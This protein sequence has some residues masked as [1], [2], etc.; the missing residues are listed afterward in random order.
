ML[1]LARFPHPVI[2]VVGDDVVDVWNSSH[3]PRHPDSSGS[4]AT[5]TQPVAGL[6]E[7]R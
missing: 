2:Y 7:I 1:P 4:G 3:P 6:E 5:G